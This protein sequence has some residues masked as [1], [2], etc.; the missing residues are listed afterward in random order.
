M[1]VFNVYTRLNNVAPSNQTHGISNN[2]LGRNS[3]VCMRDTSDSP[4]SNKFSSDV[5]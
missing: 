5:L 3:T 2:K 4:G 1:Q